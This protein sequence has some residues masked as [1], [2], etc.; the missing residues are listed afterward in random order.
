MAFAQQY[1]LPH[2]YYT[3]HHIQ[4]A[5]ADRLTSGQTEMSL[6]MQLAMITLPVKPTVGAGVWYVL[7]V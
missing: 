7:H 3:V 1:L 6:G 2:A 4:Q 5:Q